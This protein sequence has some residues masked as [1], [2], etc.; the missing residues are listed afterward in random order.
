MDTIPVVSVIIPTYNRASDL[1]RALNSVQEQ[2]FVNWEALVVDN[3]SEDNTDEIVIGFNDPRIKLFKIN[4]DGV[5][6]ASRNKGIK[7]ASG[8]YIAFLDSDDWWAPNKLELSV[9]ALKAG[10]D[11]VYHDLY[12]M[13]Y[14]NKPYFRKRIKASSP[15]LPLFYSFL[16]SGVSIPN[17][18]VVL[19]KSV[20][21]KINGV[22]EKLELISVEDFDTWVRLSKIT[23]N[24]FKIPKCL[25]YYWIGDTNS[26][27]ASSAQVLRISALYDQYLNELPLGYLLKATGFLQYRIGKIRQNYGDHSGAIQNMKEAIFSKISL[28]YRLKAVYFLSINLFL[29]W[30]R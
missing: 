10:S 25:G 23:E 22:S 20:I 14:G 2:T 26:S 8:E 11:I 13:T 30:I 5:I 1:K 16:C 27:V 18:S 15:K 24:F 9:A 12:I 6:A 4:N 29:N 7:E 17:S 19:R 3:N 21:L 28:Q